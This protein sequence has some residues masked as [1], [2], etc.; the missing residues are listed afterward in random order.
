MATT[1]AAAAVTTT[2]T[3]LPNHRTRSTFSSSF[4][5]HFGHLS[6]NSDH[7]DDDHRYFW[8]HPNSVITTTQK[9]CTT[10][11]LTVIIF[12]AWSPN[13]AS[14]ADEHSSLFSS[15]H[16]SSPTSPVRRSS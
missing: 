13:F 6:I 3:E 1:T 11:S 2:R 10:L 12:W 14:R 8:C 4:C 9:K 16:S 7:G 5:L 15:F